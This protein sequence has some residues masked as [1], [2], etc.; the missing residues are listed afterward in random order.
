MFLCD[1]TDARRSVLAFE[2]L[3][4]RGS[5]S[6]A[7]GC[8]SVSFPDKCQRLLRGRKSEL[9][10]IDVSRQ[11][12]SLFPSPASVQGE[13]GRYF[14]SRRKSAAR[15][16]RQVTR[17][18]LFFC[19]LIQIQLHLAFYSLET[20]V[21]IRCYVGKTVFPQC[22]GTFSPRHTPELHRLVTRRV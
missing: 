8:A 11:S 2:W 5:G 17:T 10:Q 14:R 20:G 19:I 22:I 3:L 9:C 12:I 18:L 13:C 1:S 16:A 7:A 4:R 6:K 15:E 21:R